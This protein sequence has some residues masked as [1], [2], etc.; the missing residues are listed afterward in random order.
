M[1]MITRLHAGA[2]AWSETARGVYMTRQ[3]DAKAFT[4]RLIGHMTFSLVGAFVFR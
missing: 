1:W 2:A 4:G 3:G